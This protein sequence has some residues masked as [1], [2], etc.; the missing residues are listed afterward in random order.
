M[1]AIVPACISL[2]MRSEALTPMACDRAETEM[3]SSMRITFLCSARSVICV[4]GPFL[5]GF[6]FLPRIG[7]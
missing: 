7:T 3:D 1:V 2:R 5:V 4:F 6:F